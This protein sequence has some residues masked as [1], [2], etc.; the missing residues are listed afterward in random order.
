MGFRRSGWAGPVGRE[1]GWFLGVSP[2]RVGGSCRCG[3][4]PGSRFWRNGPKSG[5]LSPP[6]VRPQHGRQRPP[7]STPGGPSLRATRPPYAGSLVASIRGSRGKLGRHLRLTWILE[8]GLQ[9]RPQLQQGDPQLRPAR[10]QINCLLPSPARWAARIVLP[11]PSVMGNED[12]PVAH[13]SRDGG[14]QLRPGSPARSVRSWRVPG[15]L[16]R[17]LHNGR[18]GFSSVRSQRLTMEMSPVPLRTWS[19]NPVRFAP[20]EPA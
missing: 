15:A 13:L 10:D 5:H 11:D 9:A 14:H 8:H 12:T 1:G 4:L 3:F 2:L 19:H 7:K 17:P 18:R 16:V 20:N 6:P